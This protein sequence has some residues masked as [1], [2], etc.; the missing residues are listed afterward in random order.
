MGDIASTRKEAL[1]LG[2]DVRSAHFKLGHDC[3]GE[4]QPLQ[5]NKDTKT[6]EPVKQVAVP[7]PNIQIGMT[8]TSGKGIDRFQSS[9]KF[10]NR[11]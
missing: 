11:M 8:A 3:S 1:A 9:Y 10:G 4:K 2:K 5:S 7:D 6:F